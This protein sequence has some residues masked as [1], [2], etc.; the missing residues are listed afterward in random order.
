MFRPSFLLLSLALSV[1]TFAAESSVR[2]QWNSFL[3]KPSAST[4]EPLSKTIQSCLVTK[5]HDDYIAGS[6]DNFVS[7]YKLLELVER[8]NHFAMEITFQIRPLYENAAAPSEDIGR[9]IGLS[10]SLEPTYFLELVQKYMLSDGE[11]EYLAAQTSTESIDSLGQHRAE[12]KRRVQSL[13]RVSDTRLL[14]LRDKAISFVQRE[15]DKN[16]SLPD[17]ALGA[18]SAAESSK[19][20]LLGVLEDV[21]GKYEG[22]PNSRHVRVVFKKDGEDWQ[23]F[24]AKCHDQACLKALPSDFPSQVNWTIAFDGRT[25]GQAV[26]HVPK[27]YDFYMDA[28]LQDITSEGPIPTIGQKSEEYGGFLFAAV[29]RPLVATSQP[30]FKDPDAWKP[31]HLSADVVASLRQQ[32][33]NQ[34]SKVTNCANPNENI[35]RPWRYRDQDIETHKAYSSNKNWIIAPLSL[36]GYRCDGPQD[37]PSQDAFSSQW[38]VIDPENHIELL[39]RDM[40]LV[41]AG[42]YDND[43]KSELIFAIAGYN[44]GGYELFYDDFKKRVEFEFSYH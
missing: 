43:G 2:E 28:G 10:A 9:S 39:G 36:R 19:S 6:A 20:I 17:D 5:C 16:S 30:Y 11:L 40:W 33:R 13:S 44:K 22:Q 32:F 35:A 15:I 34:F 24:P 41:D 37:G 27:A 1:T 31:A 25:L 21:P 18:P 8:G 14:P 3:T 26:T 29:L 38:F 12:W 23:P 7:L 42:D 4:Y